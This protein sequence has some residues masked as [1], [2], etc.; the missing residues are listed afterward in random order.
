MIDNVIVKNDR[1]KNKNE[2]I[3]TIQVE[4]NMPT[5]ILKDSRFKNTSL[6]SKYNDTENPKSKD[7]KSKIVANNIIIFY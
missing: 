3:N 7:K 6:K 5:T 2:T 1:L 4:K